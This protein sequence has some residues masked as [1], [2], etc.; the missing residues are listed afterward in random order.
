MRII[1]AKQ[2]F[3]KL[4]MSICLKIMEETLKDFSAGKSF[5]P[6]R[7]N[8]PLP[9]GNLLMLMP[10]YLGDD[11][12]FGAKI[13]SS[14]NSNAGSKYPTHM[15]AIML[16]DSKYGALRAIVEASAVTRIRT[17]A[18]SGVATKL[19]A[20]ADAHHL[21]I[22]G[23]GQQGRS[24]LE[25]ITNVREITHVTVYDMNQESLENY[26]NEMSEKFGIAIKSCSTI[27]ETVEN[28]DIICCLT[29]SKEPYLELEWIKK[30]AHINAVGAFSKVTREVTSELVAKSCFYADSIESIM[31]E[32]G[33]FLIPKSEGLIDDS[34]IIGEIGEVALKKVPGRQ[35]E[36]DITLFDALGLAVYDMACARYLY[37][38]N[39][40][41]E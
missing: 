29:S 6:L 20:R 36:V 12:Y 11:D 30:G 35:N 10:A 4:T 21:A 16:F 2:V 26:V 3:E 14:F 9:H 37:E 27:K 5:Q 7:N 39:P 24:H 28:A 25:A 40:E 23:T 19:L 34:H 38:L 22:I 15:G 18:V 17:G 1:E 13:I 31:N 32:C 33:E 8:V 41:A